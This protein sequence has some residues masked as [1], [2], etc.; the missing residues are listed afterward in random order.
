MQ[1]LLLIKKHLMLFM[2]AGYDQKAIDV[3]KCILR[4]N[5]TQVN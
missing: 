5:G 4:K 1:Y 3:W 2:S